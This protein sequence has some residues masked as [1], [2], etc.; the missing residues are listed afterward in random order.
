VSI[1]NK[2]VIELI[3]NI[4]MEKDS[5]YN[6]ENYMLD[7]KS[8]K[9][10]VSSAIQYEQDFLETINGYSQI[11]IYGAGINGKKMFN[12][13][14]NFYNGNILGFAV[15]DQKKESKVLGMPCKSIANWNTELGGKRNVLCVVSVSRLYWEEIGKILNKYG[16]AGNFFDMGKWI[17][18]H[19]DDLSVY[20][21]KE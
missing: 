15:S 7:E 10:V 19:G 13:L 16:L 8:I 6:I 20:P 5:C 2:D 21:D 18:M 3:K 4:N 11:L 12:I 17:I 14:N 9:Q 1:G